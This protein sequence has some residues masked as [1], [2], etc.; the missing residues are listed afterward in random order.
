[1]KKLFGVLLT[2]VVVDES[3]GDYW[4]G[5][6]SEVRIHGNLYE[7]CQLGFKADLRVPPRQTLL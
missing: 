5:H 4:L 3:Q 6:E 7:C 1:M 2:A